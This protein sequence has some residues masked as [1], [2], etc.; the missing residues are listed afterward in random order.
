MPLW[1]VDDIYTGIDLL[2]YARLTFVVD[3]STSK[4]VS[5]AVLTDRQRFALATDGD[6]A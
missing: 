2:E 6:S 5:V 1:I 4:T 3:P